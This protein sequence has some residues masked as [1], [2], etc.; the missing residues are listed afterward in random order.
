[1]GLSK[2]EQTNKHNSYIKAVGAAHPVT[3]TSGQ[4]LLEDVRANE[5]LITL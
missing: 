2:H 1:L 5:P 3:D 4:I